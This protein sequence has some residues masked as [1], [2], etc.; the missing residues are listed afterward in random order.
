MDRPIIFSGP[1]IR[2]LLEGRKTMTRRVLKPQPNIMNG[3]HPLYDGFGSYSVD[4]GW[5]LLPYAPGDRLWCRE[6]HK[7]IDR[8]CD[9]RAPFRPQNGQAPTS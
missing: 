2:A 6:A 7:I 4:G 3:N 5:K 8:H 1:M 9:Y